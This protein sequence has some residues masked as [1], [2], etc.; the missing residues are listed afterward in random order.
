LDGKGGELA[1]K[2]AGNAAIVGIVSL[3]WLL[4]R[5]GSKPSRIVYPCQRAAAVN[6]YTFLLCPITGFL[7]GFFWKIV[8]AVPH[9]FKD[10][11]RRRLVVLVLL[12]SVSL[13]SLSL[14]F[15]ANL[16]LTPWDVLRRGT[17]PVERLTSVSV[18]RV[19]DNQLEKSLETAIELIGGVESLIPIG[20]KVLIKP[21]IVRNQPPPDTTNPD[22]VVA[23]IN[24][25]QQR[26][27]SVIWVG[28]GSGEGDTLEN[29]HSLGYSAIANIPGVELVDLNSG[30]LVNVPVP[31]GGVV[32]EDFWFSSPIVEADIFISLACMKTHS[33][34]VVTMG[35]KNLVGITAGSVYGVPEWANH[36]K[37]HQIAEEK[38][39]TYL[40]GVIVDLCSARRI[41]LT[42]ID[43][44][45]AMEGQ[46]PHEGTPV[47]LGLLIIGTDP[48]A[49]DSVASA[50]MAFDPEVVPALKLAREKGLGTNELNE[51]EVKGVR[52]DDVFHPFVPAEG[53]N[54]F[55]FLRWY[56]ILLY[57]WRILLILPAAVSTALTSTSWL[58]FRRSGKDMLDKVSES[59]PMLQLPLN[60]LQSPIP[61]EERRAVQAYEAPAKLLEDEVEEHIKDFQSCIKQ[62]KETSL[63]LK[64]LSKLQTSGDIAED[65]YRQIVEEL[66]EQMSSALDNAY[67]FKMILTIAKAKARLEQAKEETDVTSHPKGTSEQED[68]RYIRAYKD[69]VESDHWRVSRSSDRTYPSSSQKWHHLLSRIEDSLSSLSIEDE[70]TFIEQYTSLLKEELSAKSLSTETEKSMSACRERLAS[71]SER[72]VPMRSAEIERV[73]SLE[74][75]FSKVNDEIKELETRFVVGEMDQAMFEHN[76]NIMQRKMEKLKKDT[77]QIRSRIDDIDAK[78]F[79]AMELLR[80]NP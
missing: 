15:Y 57:Q 28:D 1:R 4:Y 46:G 22:I 33:T 12:T 34:A 48:V 50:I 38:G 10:S 74:L 25:I 66:G 19:E 75:E 61:Q 76:K 8:S 49:T 29:F 13:V 80:G 2:I 37:L 72:W 59:H 20:S 73:L 16:L 63:S 55:Q 31:N 64:E 40:A 5:S 60:K 54:S 24:I 71:V 67:R 6:V 7:T 42:I 43:G 3:F 44:R 32:F 39:D 18:I 78:I 62:I 79:R 27:P 26:E 77:S 41:D 45:V 52:L 36:W 9:A 69:M 14:A 17:N 53:H 51:I 56:Q 11:R 47:N 23:L 21:N 58:L 65:A 68:L 35:M 70:V 30:D